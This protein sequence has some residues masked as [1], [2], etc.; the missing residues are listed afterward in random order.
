MYNKW[1][2]SNKKIAEFCV[3]MSLLDTRQDIVL[4]GTFIADLGSK[5]LSFVARSREKI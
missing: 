2:L 3:D 4:M 1:Q 5:I